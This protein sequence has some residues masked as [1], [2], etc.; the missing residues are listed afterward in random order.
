MIKNRRCI[1][2]S[3]IGGTKET[4]EMLDFCAEKNIVADVEVIPMQ[5][6]TKLTKEC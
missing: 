3:M 1:I 6:L 2:G 5:T 4:Q